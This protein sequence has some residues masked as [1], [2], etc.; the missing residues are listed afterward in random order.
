[1]IVGDLI[2]NTLLEREMSKETKGIHP[3]S[4]EDSLVRDLKKENLDF[5]REFKPTV[6]DDTNCEGIQGIPEVWLEVVND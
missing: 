5:S 3:E 6:T 1:V 4:S 2:R